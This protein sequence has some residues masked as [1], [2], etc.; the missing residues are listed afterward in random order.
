MYIRRSYSI[1]ASPQAIILRLLLVGVV[2]AL[3]VCGAPTTEQPNEPTSTEP[4]SSEPTSTGNSTP[5]T[6]TE[7]RNC[8]TPTLCE[9][10]SR[11]EHQQSMTPPSLQI[12]ANVTLPDIVDPDGQFLR[13]T[14]T[15]PSSPQNQVCGSVHSSE[16]PAY[17]NFS[18]Q[19]NYVCDYNAKRIPPYIFHAE[20]T[21]PITEEY[22][23]RTVTYPVPALYTT[24][25]DIFTKEGRWEWR[26]EQIAVACIRVPPA[27]PT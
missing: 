8:T 21:S 16:I 10:E 22:D 18:C 20:C 14:I 17:E 5:I 26:L 23:C 9:F 27:R 25:C 2:L 3:S 24:G 19:W 7:K 6:P 1:T 4:T 11:Y 13:Q 15:L 12:R